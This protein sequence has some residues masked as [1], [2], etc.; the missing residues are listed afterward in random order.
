MALVKFGA[1]I[2]Q[3]LG[4]VGGTTFARNPC[5]NYARARTKPTDPQEPLQMKVRSSMSFLT[6]RWS[7][8]LSPEDRTL[9]NQ[10]AAN[11]VM[12]NRLGEACY[13]S[14]FNHYIRSNMILK[15]SDLKLVDPGPAIHQLAAQDDTL[16]VIAS[17]IDEEMEV[18]F[19]NTMDWANETGA[20]MVLFQ[21]IPQ[22]AQRNFFAGPWRLL[23]HIIGDSLGPPAPTQAF[24]FVFPTSAGQRMWI[25]ARIIRDDG[26]LS[27]RFRTDCFI[28]V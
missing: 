10:Y 22:N 28:D 13:H 12:T 5:G 8:N 15:Q 18:S 17:E 11:V 25:Y 24:D 3:M 19:N 27:E 2:I 16:S 26:R 4:S 6:S 21:G 14:G 23:G 1:G 20:F 7:L 9:W